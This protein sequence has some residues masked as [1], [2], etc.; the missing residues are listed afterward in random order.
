MAVQG[1]KFSSLATVVKMVIEPL[2]FDAI[3]N[4]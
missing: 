2:G 3:E 4:D 1:V